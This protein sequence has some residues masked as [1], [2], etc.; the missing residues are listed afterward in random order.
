ML[1]RITLFLQLQRLGN[2][3]NNRSH[4]SACAL[5]FTKSSESVT[6]VLVL[7]ALFLLQST[8]DISNL[9]QTDF[10]QDF[11]GDLHLVTQY[12]EPKDS[13]RRADITKALVYIAFCSLILQPNRF[14]GNESAEPVYH[15]RPPPGRAVV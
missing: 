13:S 14:A 2:T 6:R 7:H 11:G 12:Y 3:N 4:T 1:C 10:L 9:A 8:L 15:S 5:C